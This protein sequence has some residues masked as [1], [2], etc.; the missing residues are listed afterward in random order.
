MTVGF[1]AVG[2]RL[3]LPSSTATTTIGSGVPAVDRAG[4]L[5]ERMTLEAFQSGLSWLIILRKRDNFRRA[6]GLRFRHRKVAPRIRQNATSPGCSP[7]KAL[8]ATGQRSRRDHRQRRAAADLDVDLSDL[9]WS[10]ARRRAGRC[11]LPNLR[12]RWRMFRRSPRNRGDG[13]DLKRRASGSWSPSTTAIRPIQRLQ[14]EWSTTTHHD[15]AQVP[16]CFS[17]GSCAVATRG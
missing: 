16:D 15:F 10:L 14:P 12:D 9:L 13:Q 8:C 6:L 11:N 2:R 4:P 5:F 17:A 1:D 7:M 3:L